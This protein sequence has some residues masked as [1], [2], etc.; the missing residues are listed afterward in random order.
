MLSIKIVDVV[1]K[2]FDLQ[3]APFQKQSPGVASI[4]S[5]QSALS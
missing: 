1:E 4:C 3:L 2:I 5:Q